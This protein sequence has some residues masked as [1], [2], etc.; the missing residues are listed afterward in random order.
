MEK[1]PSFVITNRGWEKCPRCT[2][3]G[4]TTRWHL[5]IH[6]K[7][8]HGIEFSHICE[9]CEQEFSTRQGLSSHVRVH[10]ST[11]K[12]Q[13][14]HWCKECVTWICGKPANWKNHCLEVHNETRP[15]QCP[16]CDNHYDV[17]DALKKHIER[18]HSDQIQNKDI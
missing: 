9:Y 6:L 15:F 14:E 7:H 1:I 2:D 17:H 16:T 10:K 13:Q 5:K 8:V 4:F 11:V 12:K 3:V 18:K